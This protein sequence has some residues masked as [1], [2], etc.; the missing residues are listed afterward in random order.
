M[1]VR[2]ASIARRLG[3]GVLAAAAGWIGYSAMFINHRRPLPA[4]LDF[5]RR[6][7]L[8]MQAGLLSYYAEAS[9][10]G[11]P[12]LLIHSINAA[13]SSYEMR[14]LALHYQGV[15]PV[16]ALDLPGYGFSERSRRVYRPRLYTQAILDCVENAIGEPVDA[17][18][19]SLGC[20]FLALA[21]LER[22]MLFRSLAFISPTGFGHAPMPGGSP[23]LYNALSFPVW[24]QALYD[25]L[26]SQRSLRYFLQM[27]FAGPVD[28]GMVEYAYQS[29]HQP[30]AR[31]APLTFVSGQLFTPLIR[32][33]V[34][35][36]LSTPA[37]VLY[38]QDPN[39]RFD[40]L[41]AHAE[42]YPNWTAQRIPGTRGLPHWERLPETAAA[43]ESFWERVPGL[44]ALP[45]NSS[46][47][48]NTW[49][50]EDARQGR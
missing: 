19:L 48:G 38:D 42:H 16:Y 1:P 33:Q 10:T 23:A 40:A 20:E 45:P 13:A 24:S 26:V 25:A 37:L 43:L 29:A 27:S 14:P 28:A 34:Y 15:R 11:R 31:H 8:S 4:A 35:E 3:W 22:S 17:V 44:A 5:P 39:V 21:A 7:L 2:L 32:T 50:G 12:L 6:E 36:R 49:S 18:A 46:R 9:S 30:G 47:T 41:P